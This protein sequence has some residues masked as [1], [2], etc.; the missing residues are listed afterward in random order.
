MLDNSV[1]FKI[2]LM[3]LTVSCLGESCSSIDD[4][5][6][7]EPNVACTE[8]ICQCADGYTGTDEGQ[9]VSRK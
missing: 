6:G 8:G 5:K 3:F 1:M 9:C 7:G 4:C 2:I